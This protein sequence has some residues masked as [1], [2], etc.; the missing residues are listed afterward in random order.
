M[1]S[2]HLKNSPFKISWGVL[3]LDIAYQSPGWLSHVYMGNLTE[4][5]Q[6]MEFQSTDRNFSVSW[7]IGLRPYPTRP[8]WA[9]LYETEERYF[10]VSRILGLIPSR[11]PRKSRKRSKK[12]PQKA[13]EETEEEPDFG[14]RRLFR[15]GSDDDDFDEAS[16]EGTDDENS[17]SES[18]EPPVLAEPSFLELC[19][20][21]EVLLEDIE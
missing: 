9:H 1:S 5:S 16:E 17:G 13:P 20:G 14:L 12:T 11:K 10:R 18:D 19:K 8:A 15:T 2:P 3:Q 6:T 21:L 7:L 4:A